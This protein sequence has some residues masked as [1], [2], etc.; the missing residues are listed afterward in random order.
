MSFEDKY[1]LV[2]K[3]G[4]GGFG[5]VYSGA[6]ADDPTQEVAIKFASTARQTINVML[7]KKKKKFYYYYFC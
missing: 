2:G 5:K 6:L 7:T 1:H 3:I 4:E